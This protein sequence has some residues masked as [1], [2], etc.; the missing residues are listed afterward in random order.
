MNKS[1]AED[2]E[3][4]EENDLTE[5]DQSLPQDPFTPQDFEEFWKAFKAKMQKKNKPMFNVLETVTWEIKNERHIHLT[6]ESGAMVFEFDKEKENF[7]R[8]IRKKLNNYAVMVE[9]KIKEGKKTKSHIK[10]RKEKYFE[11]VEA[12][13]LV[14]KLSQALRLDIDNEPS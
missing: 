4:E 13:P 1:I 7:I 2:N 11:F 6:F 5:I 8:C 14:Q 12:N 3:E 9:T 10:T